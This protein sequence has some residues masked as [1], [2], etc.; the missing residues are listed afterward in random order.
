MIKYPIIQ[1][2]AT[3][4]YKI[5]IICHQKYI[6]QFKWPVDVVWVSMIIGLFEEDRP[7]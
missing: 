3:Q 2:V 1:K 4:I 6:I 7:C 5:D